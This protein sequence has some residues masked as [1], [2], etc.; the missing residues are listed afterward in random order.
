[1]AT[2]TTSESL[3]RKDDS[4]TIIKNG[5]DSIETTPNDCYSRVKSPPIPM[6]QLYGESVSQSGGVSHVDNNSFNYNSNYNDDSYRNSHEPQVGQYPQPSHGTSYQNSSDIHTSGVSVGGGGL[7][8]NPNSGP[9]VVSGQGV[10]AGQSESKSKLSYMQQQQQQPTNQIYNRTITGSHQPLGPPNAPP[11]L[12]AMGPPGRAGGPHIPNSGANYNNSN[13]N[14]N[15]NNSNVN[16]NNT[17]S[18][19]NPNNNIRYPGQPVSGPT[20]TLNQLLQSPNSL[21]RYQQNN[22][23]DYSSGGPQPPPKE[24][25]LTQQQQQAWNTMRFNQQQQQIYRNQVSHTFF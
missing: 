22:Y 20:P 4:S 5:N 14:T 23:S 3:T 10:G 11:V 21:Q 2:T 6:D 19:S 8:Q 12:P 1:M 7:N 17:N 9:N 13:N 15:V 24:H 25:N 16:S 18:N